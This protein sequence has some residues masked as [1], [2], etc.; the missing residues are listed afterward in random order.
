[1]EQFIK[2]VDLYG[3]LATILSMILATVVPVLSF[4]YRKL[5]RI[6][7]ECKELL[8]AISESW[9]DRSITE[10]EMKHIMNSVSKVVESIKG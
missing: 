8:K 3:V 2:D 5:L 9:K 1:M 6:L 10:E 7:N 4:R